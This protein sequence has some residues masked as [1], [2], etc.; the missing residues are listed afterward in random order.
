MHETFQALAIDMA[1]RVSAFPTDPAWSDV[2]EIFDEWQALLANRRHLSPEAELGLWAEIWLL[3]QAERPAR[4]AE[5]WVGPEKEPTDFVVDGVGV[6]AKASR[7]RLKHFVSQAQVERPVGN[8]DSYFLS[9]WIGIDPERGLSL[10]A[11][12]DRVLAIADDDAALRRGLLRAGYSTADRELYS[13][14]Y[15]LLEMP[16]WFSSDSVPRV[17]TADPG[18]SQLRFLAELDPDRRVGSARATELWKQ[19]LGRSIESTGDLAR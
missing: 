17:R 15:V 7:T 12:V 13:R 19:F 14:P 8:Y 4:L 3:L 5:G 6:E 2:A 11:L 1:T 16:I 10:P 18:V 9:I